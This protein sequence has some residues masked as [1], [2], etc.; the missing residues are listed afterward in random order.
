MEQ[1]NG[2]SIY[3]FRK[4]SL[5]AVV[6]CLLYLVFLLPVRAQETEGIYDQKGVEINRLRL[7]TKFPT[8]KSKVE[9]NLVDRIAEFFFGKKEAIVLSKPISV[10]AENP[11]SFWVLDQGLGSLLKVQDGVGEI[12]QSFHQHYTSLVGIC[13]LPQG[14][15]LFTESRLNKVFKLNKDE[16]ADKLLEFCPAVKLDQPTGIA[17][18]SLKNE[19]WVVETALHRITVLDLQGKVIRH[20]GKRGDGP[21]EF[22]FPT[23]LWIDK[24]GLVYIVDAMNFR[25]QILNSEG[26]FI[27]MFGEIGDAT[28]Y[29]SRPKGIATDSFGN[30]YI[31]DA[32]FHAVQIFDKNG[33]F[34]YYFG[35]QGRKDGKF[36]L[37]TGIFI[38]DNDFI[39]VA[40]SYNSRIQVFQLINGR[41]NDNDKD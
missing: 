35:G 25:V 11:D 39:Y 10:F 20:I 17:F 5:K 23:F 37:P 1:M 12:P 26:E 30:I 29:F 6:F 7:V 38:D 36:W 3:S 15:L 22:N 18:S 24:S 28:G 16:S 2:L 13:A 32:L 27:S 34:L 19:V 4:L 9:V 14:D 21:L 33:N 41:L 31:V 8:E 40:D